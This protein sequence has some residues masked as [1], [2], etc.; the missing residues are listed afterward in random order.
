MVVLNAARGRVY[1]CACRS[2]RVGL[3]TCP[4]Q[5]LLA[6]LDKRGGDAP[7]ARVAGK[8][9]LMVLGAFVLEELASDRTI[10]LRA[11]LLRFQGLVAFLMIRH[12]LEPHEHATPNGAHASCTRPARRVVEVAA[13]LDSLADDDLSALGA[14]VFAVLSVVRSIHLCLI[15]LLHSSIAGADRLVARL[16]AVINDVAG[17]SRPNGRGPGRWLAA[18]HLFIPSIAFLAPNRCFVAHDEGLLRG[19]RD[20]QAALG[21]REALVAPRVVAGGKHAPDHRLPA[22]FAGHL[23]GRPSLASLSRAGGSTHAHAI[24]TVAELVHRFVLV[25]LPRLRHVISGNHVFR[26]LSGGAL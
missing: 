2:L 10:A 4:A 21:A 12:A 6:S 7:I 26:A 17:S 22:F 1:D 11:P 18:V 19:L 14:G 25:V 15:A 24:E 9:L 5:L 23:V 16:C 20:G 3:R 13:V 8:A